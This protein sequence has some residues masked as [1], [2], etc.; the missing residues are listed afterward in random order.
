LDRRPKAGFDFR[1]SRQALDFVYKHKL[2]DVQL[3][4]KFQDPDWDEVVPLPVLIAKLTPSRAEDNLAL[5]MA[6]A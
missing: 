4:V 6:A 3:V 2:H 1:H 5:A